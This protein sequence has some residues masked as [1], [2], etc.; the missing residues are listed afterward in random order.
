M[1]VPTPRVEL[2]PPPLVCAGGVSSVVPTTVTLQGVEP[3]QV[4]ASLTPLTMIG[5]ELRARRSAAPGV[6]GFVVLV[7]RKRSR[8]TPPP[9]LF[10]NLRRKSIVPKVELLTGSEVA[11]RTVLGAEPRATVESRRE[12]PN[13]AVSGTLQGTGPRAPVEFSGPGAPSVG[14]A[15]EPTGVA[16]VVETTMKSAAFSFVSAVAPLSTLRTKLYSD[17]EPVAGWSVVPSRSRSQLLP[18]FAPKPTASSRVAVETLARSDV[19][20]SAT[21]R[22]SSMSKT[23]DWSP[24]A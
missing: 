13:L 21:L 6:D 4:A 17:V 2:T 3:P 12:R 18:A 9:V 16:G 24:A 23:S 10:V 11:S 14:V 1:I 15:L 5:A 22:S 7:M 20:K 19:L 8:V